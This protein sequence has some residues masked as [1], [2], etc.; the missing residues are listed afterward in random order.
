MMGRARSRRA[1]GARLWR[2]GLVIRPTKSQNY[3]KQQQQPH[4]L[5][6]GSRSLKNAVT[7]S[8]MRWILRSAFLKAL[9]SLSQTSSECE[10]LR[11]G[12]K[13][14]TGRRQKITASTFSLLGP[15][16]GSHGFG[17]IRVLMEQV[18][19]LFFERRDTEILAG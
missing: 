10:A 8:V 1:S 12:Q 6:R 2:S 13:S 19:V 9:Y 15:R 11:S 4:P 18:R 17:E 3:N 14:G 7:G 5:K 16:S